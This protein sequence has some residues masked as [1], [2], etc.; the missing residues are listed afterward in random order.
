M[1]AAQSVAGPFLIGWGIALPLAGGS[2]IWLLW[3]AGFTP[4]QIGLMW[5][6][7]AS[8]LLVGSKAM[9]LVEAWPG[10][11][12][13]SER[14]WAALTSPALRLPGGFLLAVLA[15]PPLARLLGVPYLRFADA[16]VPASGLLILGVRVGCFLQG[17]CFGFPTT[18]PV[19]VRF[20]QATEAYFWQLGHGLVSAHDHG[21][22]PVHPLQLY[23]ALAGLLI[24]AVLVG[25]RRYQRY[26]G[27][28]LLLF[29]LLYAWSTWGLEFLRAQPHPLTQQFVLL[30]AL[31]VSVVAAAV[32]IRLRVA[33]VVATP[34]EIA[35][36]L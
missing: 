15:G 19:G 6:M 26:D 9:Y 29:V 34:L 7:L 24:F 35:A 31:A 25:Y 12:T 28:L 5:L 10:W 3:R 1:F 11:V 30:A 22:L 36:G 8:S 32:E 2:V 33:R 17:C 18:L 21:T 27:E 13:S 20:G 14:A 23:F 16:V 4:R